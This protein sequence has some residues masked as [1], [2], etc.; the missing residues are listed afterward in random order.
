MDW[1]A[2][3]KQTAADTAVAAIGKLQLCWVN[4]A[5]G[6]CDLAQKRDLWDKAADGWVTALDPSTYG[7]ADRAL[8]ALRVVAQS[9]EPG[10]TLATVCNYGCHPTS[11][12][13]PSSLISPD[14][15]GSAREQLDSICGGQ[16]VFVLGACGE[17]IPSRRNLSWHA[18]TKHAA[19]VQQVRGC[20]LL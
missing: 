9:A 19:R 10:V 7:Q 11:L 16:C 2:T 8:V 1:W 4:S 13:H 15:P 6:S 12:G 3:T 18:S 5:V 20:Q 17:T 14:W